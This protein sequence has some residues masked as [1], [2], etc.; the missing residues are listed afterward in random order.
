MYNETYH[1]V[2]EET[3][4]WMLAGESEAHQDLIRAE[5][6]AATGRQI[7]NYVIELPDGT[8]YV[9]QNGIVTGSKGYR[10]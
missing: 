8:N 6:G 4:N 2:N 9:I 3:L 5:V 10:G 7:R 1:P